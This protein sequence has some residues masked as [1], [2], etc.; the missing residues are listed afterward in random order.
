MKCSTVLATY[1]MMFLAESPITFTLPLQDQRVIEDHSTVFSSQLSK[2]RSNRHVRWSKDGR[3]ISSED[4]HFEMGWKDATHTLCII[5][6]ALED[7]GEYTIKIGEVACSATLTVDGKAPFTLSIWVCVCGCDCI[8]V[9]DCNCSCVCVR[10]V[11]CICHLMGTVDFLRIF[12]ITWR[13]T[14]KEIIANVDADVQFEW[15]LRV[16]V[17]A[18]FAA[19]VC[20]CL[21]QIH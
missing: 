7:A 12:H 4:E 20:C 11:R 17:I 5:K 13:Q 14:S 19:A 8:C 18:V 3:N 15:T 6:T 2:P 9:C 21:F 16:V 1:G 10:C